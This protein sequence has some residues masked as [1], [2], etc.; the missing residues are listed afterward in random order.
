MYSAPHKDWFKIE[1]D[2]FDGNL[3]SIPEIIGKIESMTAG[4][5]MRFSHNRE[6]AVRDY[7]RKELPVGYDAYAHGG[8]VFVL[9]YLDEEV[10]NGSQQK[11]GARGT[12]S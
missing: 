7:I 8:T 3:F 5:T 9:K 11:P 4:T 1:L 6:Y 12:G 10:D 2:L